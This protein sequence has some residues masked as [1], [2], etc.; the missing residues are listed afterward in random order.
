MAT[1]SEDTEF[2]KVLKRAGLK[3]SYWVEKFVT[4]EMDSVEALQYL[5]E[6]SQEYCTLLQSV[7]Q[8]W[9]K[10]ALKKL[11]N[12]VNED[13]KKENMQEDQSETTI[14]RKRNEKLKNMIDRLKKEEPHYTAIHASI[15]D[16]CKSFHVNPDSLLKGKSLSELISQLEEHHVKVSQM[17]QS[18]MPQ[19]SMSRSDRKVLQNVS[20]GQAL[21][22]ILLSNEIDLLVEERLPLLAVPEEVEFQLVSHNTTENVQFFHT[23][24]LEETYKKCVGILDWSINEINPQMLG[25]VKIDPPFKRRNEGETMQYCCTLKQISFQLASYT[26]KKHDLNL[27]TDAIED[28][29]SLK[30][31]LTRLGQDSSV[32]QTKCEGFF[33][34]YGSHVSRGPFHFG[35]IYWMTC[36]SSDFVQTEANVIKQLQSE[37]VSTKDFANFMGFGISDEVDITSIKLNYSEKCSPTTLVNT[38]LIVSTSGGLLNLTSLPEWRTLLRTNNSTWSIIHRGT[39]LVP[40]WDII[41]MNYG[42]ELNVLVK[43]LRKAWENYTNL[44]HH[45]NLQE[46]VYRCEHVLKDIVAW[47]V[48]IDVEESLYYLLNIK[49]ELLAKS[50]RK[51]WID[52]YLLHPDFQTYI[53]ALI[54]HHKKLPNGESCGYIKLLMQQLV[55]EVDVSHFS[56]STFKD[57]ETIKEWLFKTD[58]PTSSSKGECSDFRDLVELLEKQMITFESS[59]PKAGTSSQMQSMKCFMNVTHD[60]V[61]AIHSLRTH[62]KCM[63]E[64]RRLYD[65]LFVNPRRMR[66]R[67]LQ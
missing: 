18:S 17:S 45:D 65:D 62:I 24:F 42:R 14:V 55:E 15:K 44:Q 54:N 64:S 28:L 51:A 38:H 30:T 57:I 29:R 13:D 26:F 66:E 10:K 2:A 1:S 27:S 48:D 49:N 43:V 60:I 19:S 63:C 5:E 33:E 67:G 12:L 40:V 52:M 47:N 46:T 61:L 6:G 58:P 37:A 23:K 21:Q 8:P 35:G 41:A 4:L 3:L 7:R 32:V 59:K 39:L 16:T 36:S 50:S 56:S 31:L 9:E 22:G 20:G 11:L 25:A 34:K 53:V